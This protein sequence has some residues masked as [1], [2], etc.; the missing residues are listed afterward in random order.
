MTSCTDG[1]RTLTTTERGQLTARGIAIV[2]GDAAGASFEEITWT[3]SGW[4]MR[5]YF[6]ATRSSFRRGSSPTAI[7][8]SRSAAPSTSTAGR[9]RTVMGSRASPGCGWP[10]TSPMHAPRSSP[11]AGEGSAAAIAIDARWSTRTCATPVRTHAALRAIGAV[12]GGN[13][14]TRREA[15][16]PITT[17]RPQFSRAGRIPPPSKH[18]LGVH[19]LAQRL[20]DAHRHQSRARRLV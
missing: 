10:A 9:S 12:P 17:N 14:R 4:R 16:T 19:D 2:E 20:P 13:P 11:P 7:F 3:P 1:A 18:H 8:S 15:F 6:A 5:P